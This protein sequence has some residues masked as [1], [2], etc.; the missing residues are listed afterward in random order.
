MNTTTISIIRDY[1]KIDILEHIIKNLPITNTRACETI[2][3][4]LIDSIS[5]DN[6]QHIQMY[7]TSLHQSINDNSK[8]KDILLISTSIA[9]EK[10]LLLSINI[11]EQTN[12]YIN[13]T[14]VNK[15]KYPLL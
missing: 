13:Y 14:L 2:I 12:K 15:D 3:S 5:A 1:D 8:V 11:N 6:I 10:P 7:T 4:N 9:K